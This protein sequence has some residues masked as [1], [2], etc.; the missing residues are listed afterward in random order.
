MAVLIEEINNI[1]SSAYDSISGS[2]SSVYS[3]VSGSVYTV[4]IDSRPF[5]TTPFTDYSVIEGL[6]LIIILLIIIIYLLYLLR[7]G[8]KWFH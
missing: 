2:V 1:V 3:G 6:L 7:K 5:L 8:F 4:Q